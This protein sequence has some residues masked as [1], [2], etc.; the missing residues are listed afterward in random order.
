MESYD[1]T[2]V[3]KSGSQELQAQAGDFMKKLSS[4]MSGASSMQEQQ[5]QQNP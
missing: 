2:D 3:I 4:M 5:P 1:L